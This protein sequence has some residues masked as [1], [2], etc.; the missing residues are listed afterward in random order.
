MGASKLCYFSQRPKP[1]SSLGI[2]FWLPILQFMAMLSVASPAANTCFGS[3][4]GRGPV[5]GSRVVGAGAAPAVGQWGIG[6]V[7]LWPIPNVKFRPGRGCAPGR[8]LSRQVVTNFGIIVITKVDL[9]NG[10]D[11]Q[12]CATLHGH[13]HRELPS[14]H[15]QHIR[16]F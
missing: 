11:P 15:R 4:E 5:F 16:S 3:G 7:R 8:A 1:R 10:M 13:S 9:K 6:V 12:M 14:A 2:G